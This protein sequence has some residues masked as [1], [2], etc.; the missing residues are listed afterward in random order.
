[1]T[2]NVTIPIDQLVEGVVEGVT[3]L[4]H[5]LLKRGDE[6]QYECKQTEKHREFC[7]TQVDP[8]GRTISLCEREYSHSAATRIRLPNSS[9]HHASGESGN[10]CNV[11]QKGKLSEDIIM[12]ILRKLK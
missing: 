10:Y 4:T 11:L 1:M 6:I 3:T 2:P 9:L 8:F 5:K 12:Q 7:I